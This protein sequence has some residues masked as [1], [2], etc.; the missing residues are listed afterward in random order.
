MATPG[1]A[2]A[3][4]NLQPF[5][6]MT[7]LQPLSHYCPHPFHTI[8]LNRLG[9]FHR[10][11]L[12]ELGLFLDRGGEATIPSAPF[13]LACCRCYGFFISSGPFL[14]SL[15]SS[16]LVQK[17]GLRRRKCSSQMV[18]RC[19]VLCGVGLHTGL[20]PAETVEKAGFGD[21]SRCEFR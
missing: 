21:V 16:L 8:D 3:R 17:D 5:F 2:C 13:P 15:S 9:S 19:G 20:R 12:N 18:A 1:N 7:D 14:P 10:R 4:S 11:F 6:A